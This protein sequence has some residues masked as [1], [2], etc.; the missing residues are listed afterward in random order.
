MSSSDKEGQPSTVAVLEWKP[1]PIVADAHMHL[2]KLIDDTGH[3]PPLALLKAAPCC[4]T[5]N[6]KLSFYVTNFS[7]LDKHYNHWNMCPEAVT[8]PLAKLAYSIHPTTAGILAKEKVPQLLTK[9]QEYLKHPK[10]VA[11]A[12]VGLDFE[13][14][15]LGTQFSN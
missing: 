10:V 11:L 9:L 14:I 3:Q 1:V 4:H 8:D 2:D 13:K 15:H 12:E 6:V 5:P 7:F